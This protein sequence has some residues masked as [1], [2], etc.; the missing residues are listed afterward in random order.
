MAA[1][2]PKSAKSESDIPTDAQ[3]LDSDIRQLK[4]DIAQLAKQISAVG[5]HSYGA[6]RRA[7]AEGADRLRTQSGQA[8]ETARSSAEDFQ[9]QLSATVR[10]K[11]ITAL[12]V[13]AGIGYL[14]ALLSRR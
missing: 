5:E 6:A 7:A 11:P 9:E 12:A 10:E 13:A 4:E 2:A 14:I 8:L 3:T 1:A